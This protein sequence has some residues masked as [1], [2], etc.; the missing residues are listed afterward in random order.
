MERKTGRDIANI[1]IPI[2]YGIL[3]IVVAMLVCW[4]GQYPF[5]SDTMTYIYRG[6]VV[7][8]AIGEGNFLPLYDSMWY[9]GVEVFGYCAPL[10]LYFMAMCQALVGG[11]SI[12]GYL[13]FTG[14]VYFM[15]AMSW[16]FVGKKH[17][18]VWLG[19]FVG[20]LWFF[21]PHNLHTMFMEGNLA[22]A[23]CMVFL[24]IVISSVYDYMDESGWKNLLKMMLGYIGI[25]LC[26]FDYVVMV[27]VGIVLFL[28][29]YGFI[30]HVW[31]KSINVVIAMITSFVSTLFWALP[32]LVA[33]A[34]SN[35][36]ETMYRYFQSLIKSLNPI[37][38]YTSNHGYYY[39][40]LAVFLLA[41]FGVLCSKRKSLPG[42][43]TGILLF[44]ATS[45]SMYPVLK[46]I[47]GGG[48]LLMCQYIS[49]GLCLVLYAWMQWTTLRKWMQI[50]VCVVLVLDIVP[51]LGLVCGTMSG[52][53]V[54]ER[55]G[56]QYTTTMIEKAQE[57]CQQRMA[58]IDG[59]ELEAT[60][61]YLVSSYENGKP[62]SYGSDWRASK[63][64]SN[65]SQLDI[66]I[67]GG[68]YPYVFDRCMELGNDT[69]LIKLSQ[70]N[71]LEVPIEQLD[72]AATAVGYELV[73]FNEFYRLY[74]MDIEGTWGT[75][76]TYSAI[77]IGD[78]ANVVALTYP[79]AEE[80]TSP[81][82]DDYTFEELMKYKLV[83]LARF[84]YH[85]RE[86]A[87]NLVVKLSESGVHVFILADGIPEDRIS[88]T[89]EFLGVSCND[90]SFSNGY[91]LL[92]TKFGVLD[93][94]FFPQGY[95]EWST[96]YVNGLDKVLGTV[97]EEELDLAFF[98]TVV[99][100]NIAV[101]GLNLPYYYSLTRDDGAA[102][103]IAE[104]TALPEGLLPQ[105]EVV[106]ITVSYADNHFI[107][108]SERNNVNTSMAYL[109]IFE[110]NEYAKEVNNFL[111]V[112]AG[113][114]YVS[115]QYPYIYLGLF[116]SIIG[117]GAS[118]FLLYVVAKNEDE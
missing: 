112:N 109:D 64:Q 108:M 42:L 50:I 103:I 7:Y 60:G 20:A 90:I 93:P 28:L 87:E 49:I 15:G 117:L 35:A 73:G 75:V 8:K 36:K 78:D 116:L 32:F 97:R 115:T 30:C 11:N 3:A 57:V 34:D 85:D 89:T 26:D 19:A 21:M 62:G 110:D 107:I 16:F 67:N 94:D 86:T 46:I 105:R 27:S 104:A 77:G 14:L 99:N 38:R 80:G 83:Y 69:V 98:G 22:R 25:A 48:Y 88:H 100:D 12:D 13:M 53:P 102:K 68:F 29:V 91:P 56:E 31:R 43:W 47:P 5:G 118:V 95:E 44:L 54:A 10:P 18:R 40:G 37:E 70:A 24:P 114:T 81:Y 45:A 82:V 23:L 58:F 92:D 63:I 9:N 51:S 1:I 71:L 6:E 106:P 59:G 79:A 111:Y 74:D 96:V 17:G 39:F 2:S 55:F 84:R 65:L 41:V 72:A 61:T 52:V 4:S 76:T 66:A 113:V 101:V 33:N